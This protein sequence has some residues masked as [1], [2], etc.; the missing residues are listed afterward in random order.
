MAHHWSDLPR[1]F[2]DDWPRDLRSAGKALW[3]WHL[4]LLEVHP[5]SSNG[6]G[7]AYGELFEDDQQRALRGEPLR[8]LREPVW[9]AAYEACEAHDLS[10]KLL[11]D[12]VGA[13]KTLLGP[14]RFGDVQALNT[15]VERWAGAHT[16]LLAGLA[17]ATHTWQLRP[18]DELGR[19]FFFVGR[20]MTLPQDVTRDQLFMPRSDL[21]QYGVQMEQL[22]TGDLDAGV[23]KLLWKQSIRARDALGQG[24]SLIRDLP[25]MRRFA[26]KR[27]WHGALEMLN[28]IERHDFDVWTHPPE[29]SL[30][31]RMQINLQALFGK[32]AGRS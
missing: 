13:A 2:Y 12:Q 11:A 15:F 23:R 31:R 17:D 28:Y 24:Q 16:R 21:E 4:S 20:L 29:L 10:L 14:V 5:P 3:Q 9:R 8:L 18:V 27:W 25:R 6:A 19:G 30:F 7:S 1:P 32:A 22:Q 26:L